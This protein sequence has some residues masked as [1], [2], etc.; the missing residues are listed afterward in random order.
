MVVT[1]S[2]C[3]GAFSNQSSVPHSSVSD[4]PDCPFTLG[5][6]AVRVPGGGT[7]CQSFA[8]FQ[9]TAPPP[10]CSLH[11]AHSSHLACLTVRPL[12]VYT[13]IKLSDKEKLRWQRQLSVQ[14]LLVARCDIAISQQQIFFKVFADFQ[15]IDDQ[16]CCDFF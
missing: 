12:A 8:L 15:L 11:Q 10:P 6:L 13:I 1:Y 14:A 5:C 9:S 16:T 7:H 2:I 3:A 4:S